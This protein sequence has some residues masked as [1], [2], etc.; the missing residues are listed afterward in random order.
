M[1]EKPSVIIVLSEGVH[2]ICKQSGRHGI[3]IFK[4]QKSILWEQFKREFLVDSQ[5]KSEM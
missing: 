2:R 5:E 3:V 4:P 1:P